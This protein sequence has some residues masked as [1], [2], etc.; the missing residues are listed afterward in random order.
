[1][2]S[3]IPDNAM[4]TAFKEVGTIHVSFLASYFDF[5]A[6]GITIVLTCTSPITFC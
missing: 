6:F 5:F 3:I 1:M 4:S 2:D